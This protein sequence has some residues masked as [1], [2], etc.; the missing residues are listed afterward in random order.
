MGKG[1]SPEQEVVDYYLSIHYGISVT[2]DSIHGIYVGEKTAW[3]G[4]VTDMGPIGISAPNLFGGNKKEGGVQ[5]TAYFLPG[6]SDQVLPEVLAAKV[7]RTSATAPAYRGVASLWFYGGGTYGYSGGP[8]WL[9]PGALILGGGGSGGFL[10]GSNNPYLRDIWIKVRRAPKGLGDTLS[11]MIGTAKSVAVQRNNVTVNGTTAAVTQGVS[12]TVNGSTVLLDRKSLTIDATE[13]IVDL[14]DKFVSVGGISKPITGST[15]MITVNG[16][17]VTITS[18]YSVSLGPASIKVANFSARF[19]ATTDANPIHIIYECMTNS[20]WG[21]GG[22]PSS[23]DIPNWLA[24]AQTIYDEGFGMSLIW[25]QQSTVE[26]FVGEIIDHIQ[27]TIFINPRTGLWTIKLIRDDY[28]VA[29]LPVL[30][31]DNC[32]ITSFERKAWGETTNEIVVTWTNP[33]N[34]QEET[35]S[36][37]D[38]ANI[39]IQGAVISDSRNYYGI[40]NAELAMKIAKRDLRMASAPLAIFELEVDRDAWDFVPGGVV[41]LDYPEPDYEIETL[42]LRISKIDYGRPGD[43][44]IKVN[45]VEDIFALP[46]AAYGLPPSTEWVSPSELPRPMDFQRTITAPLYFTT[47]GTQVADNN[48]VEFPEV[49]TMILAAQ[50][51]GDT[52]QFD[53]ITDALDASGATIQENVGTRSVVGRA[54]ISDALASE[55]VSLIDFEDFMGQ[56]GADANVFVFIGNGD[57]DEMEIALITDWDEDLGFTLDRGVLDT[58]PRAWPANTPVWFVETN[59]NIYDITLRAGGETVTYKLLT[60]TS[61]GILDVDDATT[62]TATLTDRPWLP[63]RPGDVKVAGT[64]FGTVALGS[65]ATVAVTWA[66]RNR[67]ME[68]TQ[69]VLWGDATITPE[70]GQTTKITVMRPDRTVITTRAGLTGTSYTMDAVDFGGETDAIVRVT[71][72]RD[73]LESLQGHEI[74]VTLTG[75]NARTLSG[76]EAGNALKPSGDAQSGT[77]VRLWS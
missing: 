16:V 14:D 32:E 10:W 45:A 57:E 61:L 7:G 13:I 12:T 50:D 44:T 33:A 67:L 11:E 1:G 43:S 22:A 35:V 37:Q 59:G 34:E 20:D 55:A 48:T 41:V 49:I 68:P 17:T 62:L 71:A 64:G 46:I 6:R 24:A 9:G 66:N 4:S 63:N 47:N 69:V 3:E 56:S 15:K 51:S 54:V 77:D 72:E 26:A 5:G 27:A 36:A 76:D 60:R 70:A 42:V 23:F 28:D 52:A 31:R 75:R 25:A 21:M 8:A 40:R 30:N 73:G 65:A 19:N 29:T 18:S 58:V 74:A 53:V 38:L 2:V 39:T